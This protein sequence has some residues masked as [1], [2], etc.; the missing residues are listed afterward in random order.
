MMSRLKFLP[1]SPIMALIS[2]ILA[3]SL[4]YYVKMQQA[5]DEIDVHLEDDAVVA[6]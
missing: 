5:S 4:W 6:E 2:L 3:L 1:R